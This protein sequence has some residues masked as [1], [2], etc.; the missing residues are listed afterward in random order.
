[1]AAG[2]RAMAAVIDVV[3]GKKGKF[4]GAGCGESGAGRAMAE[5]VDRFDEPPRD[6]SARPDTPVATSTSTAASAGSLSPYSPPC[7]PSASLGL[8]LRSGPQRD[9]KSV[10]RLRRPSFAIGPGGRAFSEK[11]I[12]PLSTS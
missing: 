12:H 1:M 6:R 8:S 5:M 2:R 3:G 10:A 4:A 11:A 9:G 7:S